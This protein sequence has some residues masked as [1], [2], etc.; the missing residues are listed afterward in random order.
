MIRR[1]FPVLGNSAGQLNCTAGIGLIKTVGWLHIS[2]RSD[3][4]VSVDT[5]AFLQS[6]MSKK[7]QTYVAVVL[8]MPTRPIM[9]HLVGSSKKNRLDSHQLF[10]SILPTREEQ[11]ESIHMDDKMMH[12]TSIQ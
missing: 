10:V 6:G 2:T 5:A 3:Y 9:V 8:L 11:V 7:H 4:T 12:R 1:H